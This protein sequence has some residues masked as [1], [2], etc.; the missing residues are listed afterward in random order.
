MADEEEDEKDEAEEPASEK[1]AS[2]KKA[3]AEEKADAEKK[4]ET[5]EPEKPVSKSVE[6]GIAVAMMVVLIGFLFM[7]IYLMRSARSAVM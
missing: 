1:P 3:D 5:S 6:W 4:A 2:E 7:M